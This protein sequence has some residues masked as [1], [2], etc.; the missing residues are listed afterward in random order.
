MTAPRSI[1]FVG[2]GAMG[3]AVA[4]RISTGP[5]TVVVHDLSAAAVAATVAAGARAAKDAAARSQ[6]FCP[7]CA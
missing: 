6:R 1:G 7:H 3:G 4:R 5:W 2:L